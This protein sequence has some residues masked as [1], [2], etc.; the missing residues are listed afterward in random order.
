MDRTRKG[1]NFE[2]QLVDIFNEHVRRSKW[3]R[4]PTSG[5]MGTFLNEPHLSGD[6]N[7]VLDAYPRRFKIESKVGYGGAKQLTL[8]KEWIDKVREEAVND[9]H[10]I[11]LLI[12]KFSGAREGTRV[13]I[14]MDVD[15][16][17]DFL[18]YTTELWEQNEQKDEE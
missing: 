8:K 12:G 15:T 1:R 2:Y 13:F 9:S 11:P 7:G 18:N 14:V 10:S 5:A 4:N 17:V 6:V 3:K 16:F